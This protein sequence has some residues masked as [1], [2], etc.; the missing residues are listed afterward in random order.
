MVE[1]ERKIVDRIQT[2]GQPAID[3][4]K[5]FLRAGD[6]RPIDELLKLAGVDPYD[7][8]TYDF[9]KDQLKGLV[10]QY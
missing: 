4:Y 8:A 1:G 3:D 7:Q 5:D 9:A 6:S 10:D 2:L